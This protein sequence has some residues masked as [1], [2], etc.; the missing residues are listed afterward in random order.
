MEAMLYRDLIQK[1]RRTLL[2]AGIEDGGAEAELLLAHAVGRPKEF[3]IAHP[4]KPAT[5]TQER[6][7]LS[8]LERRAGHEPIAYLLGYKDFY[9]RSF[10]VDRNVLIPRPETETLV[11]AALQ[12]LRQSSN[13][14]RQTS[15]LDIGAGSGAVVLTLVSEL[16]GSRAVAA[17]IS[18]AA[19]K[20]ARKNAE[21]FG[22]EDRVAFVRLDVMDPASPA[23]GLPPGRLLLAANLPYL[24]VRA[25][26]SL[27][28]SIRDHEPAIALVSGS[29][30]LDH[31]RALL[32]RLRDWKLSP[33]LLLL[34]ADPPQIFPLSKLVHAALPK[35]RL[36]VVKDLG[37][38]DRILVAERQASGA[39]PNK[40]RESDNEFSN[41]GSRP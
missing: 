28:R 29:D 17:D 21:R 34:E 18:P 14:K 25:M 22:V 1:G 37:G 23:P 12:K 19:L 10:L 3:V 30:G 36:E 26:E 9:G 32:R 15:I 8:L 7:Y 40:A 27:P 13:A 41:P 11:E 24:S 39:V 33:D 31:Y 4:E 2:A 38:Q 16:P 35:H 5:R 6:A 20:L